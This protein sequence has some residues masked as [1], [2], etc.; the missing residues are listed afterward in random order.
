MRWGKNEDQ[1]MNDESIKKVEQV[2]GQPVLPE[3]SEDLRRTKRN[4]LIVSSVVIF[5]QMS[6]IQVTETGFLGFKFSNPDQIWLR[7]GLLSVT[8]YLFIQF[9]WRMWD[10]ILHIRLRLT[11]N[12]VSHVTTAI[13]ASEY[14]DYP[15]D[16]IQSTLY[17]WWLE[18]AHR[19]GN[20]SAIADHIH[21]AADSLEEVANRP[22]NI[23]MPNINHVQRA[24][25]EIRSGMVKLEQRI[26]EVEKAIGSARILVSLQ[27]FDRWFRC[28]QTSQITRVILLDVVFPFVFAVTGLWLT[29]AKMN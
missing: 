10:Y 9:C 12:R 6:G 17:N 8:V 5:A 13:I 24:A 22:G 18:K 28:F 23:E 29:I 14:G 19:I 25:T 21:S 11:G 15:S 16:P 7:L 3:F 27:R 2:L 4:L 20:L 26:G 1:E